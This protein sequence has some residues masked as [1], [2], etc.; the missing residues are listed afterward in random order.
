MT[1]CG[2][3]LKVLFGIPMAL[4]SVFT[5][6]MCILARWVNCRTISSSSFLVIFIRTY[7]DWVKVPW[8]FGYQFWSA[9]VGPPTGPG[10]MDVFGILWGS[11]GYFGEMMGECPA[12]SARNV[13][14]SLRSELSCALQPGLASFSK[15]RRSSAMRELPK[16]SF[17]KS[18]SIKVGLGWY[19]LVPVRLVWKRHPDVP[20]ACDMDSAGMLMLCFCNSGQ[21]A[22]YCHI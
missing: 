3:I 15:V 5:L 7:S 21:I 11:L 16:Q 6:T 20:C 9:C 14:E 2:W 17:R 1:Q 8:H 10:L 19:R 18:C 4:W 22:M 13:W 12:G